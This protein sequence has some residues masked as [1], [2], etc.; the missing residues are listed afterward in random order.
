MIIGIFF[1]IIIVEFSMESVIENVT[2]KV[3]R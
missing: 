3:Y 1:Q 2:S